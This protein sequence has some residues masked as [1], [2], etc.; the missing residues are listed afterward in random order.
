MIAWF[1]C[2]VAAAGDMLLGALVDAGADLAAIE[3]QLVA[4]GLSPGLRAEEVRRGALRA[5]YVRGTFE[6]PGGPDDGWVAPTGRRRPG[7]THRPWRLIRELI[8]RSA[9][10]DRARARALSAYGRLA[11]AEARLHGMPVDDVALHEVGSDDAICDIVG[12]C[13]ALEQLDVAQI[14]ATPLPAGT[15]S[16]VAAHGALPLPAP[17]TLEVLRG[18]PIVPARWPGEWVTPTG[19]ALVSALATPG[20]PPA[21]TVRAVGYGAGR[22]DPPQVANLVRVVLGDAPSPEPGGSTE[23]VTELTCQLD[24]QAGVLLAP[25]LAALLDAGALD[26]WFVPVIMKKGRPGTAL[27]ALTRPE[28]AS[29]L[30]EL[31][32][33][34]TNT[35]GVRR[36]DVDRWVLDRW[37]EVVATEHGPVT[38][39]VAGRD[40]Q[41]WRATPETDEVLARAE[42]AGVPAQVVD[43]AARRAWRPG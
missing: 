30:A 20:G 24:D 43:A 16:I 31:V 7:H 8:E 34:H 6:E 40:G 25:V 41:A 12:V 26:A 4:L 39:K 38:M 32:L 2:Q 11:H 9:L 14:V 15:G 36:R 27:H 23:R 33:R 37:F 29:R 21:M 22:K 28:D 10:P 3:A 17:A 42:A 5:R 35:L 13:L 1:D 19:A 18:W